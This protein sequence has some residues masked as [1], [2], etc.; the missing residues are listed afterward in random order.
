MYFGVSEIWV[1][2]V[3]DGSSSACVSGRPAYLYQK[4]HFSADST[5]C[6]TFREANAGPYPSPSQA[7]RREYREPPAV[8]LFEVDLATGDERQLSRRA[9][10][11]G[12]AYYATDRV[13][14][15][16]STSPPLI[17]GEPPWPGAPTPYRSP[18]YATIDADEAYPFGG[19]FIATNEDIGGRPAAII[20]NSLFQRDQ[21]RGSHARL[22]DVDRTGQLVVVFQHPHANAA[23]GLCESAAIVSGGDVRRLIELG[24]PRLDSPRISGDGRTLVGLLGARREGGTNISFPR[25]DRPFEFIVDRN[26]ARDDFSL[27][28]VAIQDEVVILQAHANAE[29]V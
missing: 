22:E 16:L 13:G 14:Y 24:G 6:L 15:Y 29:I 2:D 10:H 9:F 19:F 4:P 18:S 28:D 1:N 17:A 7:P 5:K 26:G 12:R 11:S 3:R 27:A 21:M 20:P 25:S 8:S 23:F